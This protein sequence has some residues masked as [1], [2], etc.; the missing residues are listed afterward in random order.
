MKRLLILIAAL[1]VCAALSAQET[2]ESGTFVS[3]RGDTLLYRLLRPADME[4]GVKYP[5]VLFM[6]GAG[7]RGN[8]N[9]SQLVHGGNMFLNPVNREKYPA[10]VLAPQCPEP[11]YWAYPSRPDSFYPMEMPEDVPVSQIFMTLKDLLDV[12]LAMPEVD[13]DRIYVT[14]L[15][16]GGMATY[17]LAIRFPEIFAAAV[18]VCGTV[19]PA[20]L[21]AARQVKFRIFHGDA[22]TTVP[23][24]GSRE[25][26]LALKKAGAS[27]EYTEFPGC[28]HNSWNPAYNLPD[29]MSWLFSQRKGE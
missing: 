28:G 14:G 18:P 10:F 5:L 17:D 25:A 19:N 24:E 22:D 26:Y 29:F 6:H 21:A 15:S 2:Y 23:V 11:L 13:T 20:R 8:D 12:F 9:K 3:G 27:V 16:M 7:E 1:C 4:P